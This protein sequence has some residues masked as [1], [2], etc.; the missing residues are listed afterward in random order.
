MIGTNTSATECY[1]YFYFWRPCIYTGRFWRTSV[2]CVGFRST[3]TWLF[4]F[5]F[6][7]FVN[8]ANLHPPLHPHKNLKSPTFRKHNV[9]SFGCG[10]CERAAKN[11][12]SQ[13]GL[14][15]RNW[16][17]NLPRTHERDAGYPQN[18]FKP[19]KLKF[20]QYVYI[21]I[22]IFICIFSFRLLIFVFPPLNHN[23]H[24]CKHRVKY[25]SSVKSHTPQRKE[26]DWDAGTCRSPWLT[27]EWHR[28]ATGFSE[29]PKLNTR[30]CTLSI[31]W[32][33]S[34]TKGKQTKKTTKNR[35]LSLSLLLS[36]LLLHIY[37][38]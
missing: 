20:V 38:F 8:F 24:L 10:H 11:R 6:F 28:T 13:N 18:S 36:A 3:V 31:I 30:L 16:V 23:V 37:N 29:G 7:F 9:R 2:S 14:C 26:I 19:L 15:R 22:Y 1:S 12:Q 33:L 25:A 4:S 17:Q 27:H 21:Y 32:S 34:Q 5:L 35:I